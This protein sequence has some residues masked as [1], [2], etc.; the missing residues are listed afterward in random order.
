MIV[1]SDQ[2]KRRKTADLRVSYSAEELTYAAQMKLRASGKLSEAR[3]VQEITN[4]NELPKGNLSHHKL[5][6]TQALSLIIEAQL[7][8]KKYNLIRNYAKDVFP[9]YKTVK[10]EKA[11]SYPKSITCIESQ[12]EVPLQSLLDH[13]ASRLLCVQ[14]EVMISLNP[15]NKFILDVKWGFDGS[16]SHTQYMQ[17]FA[18]EKTHDKYMFLTSLVPIRLTMKAEDESTTVIWKNPRPSS[19]R[20]CRPI[21]MQYQKETTELSKMIKADICD[22]GHKSS[23]ER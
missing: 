15:E 11:S 1:V 17:K 20:F 2:T 22:S 7:S 3:Q 4:P 14:K 21:K 12:A 8:K 10:K 5:T 13:T 16:S 19:P 6:P 9:S 23:T 18:S